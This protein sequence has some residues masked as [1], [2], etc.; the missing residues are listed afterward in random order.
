MGFLVVFGPGWNDK[1]NTRYVKI[2]FACR[3]IDFVGNSGMPGVD[4]YP[5]YS[6]RLNESQT[7]IKSTG[8]FRRNV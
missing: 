4:F 2:G 1:S 7:D 3:F 5:V 8:T 6:E